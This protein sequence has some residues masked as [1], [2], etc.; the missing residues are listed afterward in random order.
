M[1]VYGD[2]VVKPSEVSNL[3]QYLESAFLES[4]LNEAANDIMKDI[5]ALMNKKEIKPE[6]FKEIASRIKE[7]EDKKTLNAC[8]ALF[9]TSYIGALSAIMVTASGVIMPGLALSFAGCAGMVLSVKG[10]QKASIDQF[11]Y[12][13]LQLEA[14]AKKN[15]A[16]AERAEDE[17]QVKTC[18]KVIEICEKLRTERKNYLTSAARG[19]ENKSEENEEVE[20]STV[21]ESAEYLTE[22]KGNEV[23]NNVFIQVLDDVDELLRVF[24]DRIKLYDE[25]ATKMKAIASTATEKN[26]NDKLVECRKLGREAGEEDRKLKGINGQ[27][28]WSLVKM[29]VSKFNNKYSY[30]TMSEKKKLAAKMQAYQ[31]K[32]NEYAK[33]YSSDSPDEEEWIKLLDKLESINIS[34]RN[35]FSS[36]INS[37]M[38]GVISE[39]NATNNDINTTLKDLNI[40][41]TEKSIV[42]KVLNL[43]KK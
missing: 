40:E 14:K 43:G 34:A 41:K 1:S 20:E 11:Y 19:D 8:V 3:E 4:V 33:K 30:I 25:T 29:E 21:F 22:F 26:I 10:M 9:F 39:V 18:E 16:R 23:K 13:L 31:K 36:L 5:K 27:L 42:Y 37:W 15:K 2:L 7:I 38:N 28:T 17:E 32:L 35:E 6:E 24:M 12:K